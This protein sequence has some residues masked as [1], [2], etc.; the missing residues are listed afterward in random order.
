M[1]LLYCE[2]PLC[3]PR[4][5][6]VLR[7]SRRSGRK[8]R[9]CEYRFGWTA[10]ASYRVGPQK[11]AKR[12]RSCSGLRKTLPEACPAAVSEML[13]KAFVGEANSWMNW[14]VPHGEA[15]SSR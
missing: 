1:Q 7:R 11:P 6:N 9:P 10:G 12:R 14:W 2:D 3:R 4:E 15:C 13:A 8:A 5:P